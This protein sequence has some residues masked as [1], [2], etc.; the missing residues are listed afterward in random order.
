M[1]KQLWLRVVVLDRDHVTIVLAPNTSPLIG[2][3]ESANDIVLHD[4][5][6]SRMHARIA[7]RSGAYYVQDLGSSTGTFVD[8]KRVDRDV[9]L[10]GGEQI[11][12]GHC[13]LR[14]VVRDWTHVDE[15]AADPTM[16]ESIRGDRR[17]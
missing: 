8:G 3:D 10:R 5:S 16:V 15:E 6:V 9:I 2:R 14:A 12:I 1:A 7:Y 11:E 17:R 4:P 13:V